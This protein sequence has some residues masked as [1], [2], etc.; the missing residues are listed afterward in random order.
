[1]DTASPSN[2]G[3]LCRSSAIGIYSAEEFEDSESD[4][5]SNEDE[6]EGGD[7]SGPPARMLCRGVA[8]S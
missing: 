7:G 8:D 5:S 6:D 4:D 2:H 1:M 3:L